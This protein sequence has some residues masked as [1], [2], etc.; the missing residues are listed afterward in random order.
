[1][2]SYSCWGHYLADT[3]TVPQRT[4]HSERSRQEPPPATRRRYFTLARANLALVLVKR[5]IADVVTEYKQM[6]ELQESLEAARSGQSQ[7]Q[8]A[9][10]REELVRAAGK[11]RDCLHELEEIGVELKDW[12]LGVVDFPSVAG[13][14]EVYLCWQFG[15]ECIESWHEIDEDPA[16]RRPI[17]E[18]PLVDASTADLYGWRTS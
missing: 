14:R 2:A 5:V 13:P 8:V 6:L 1:M 9:A 7:E 15:Q 10:A 16:V 11:L 18:L 17:E 12:S 4:H 3:A